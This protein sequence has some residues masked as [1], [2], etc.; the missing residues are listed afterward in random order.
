MKKDLSKVKIEEE[1]LKRLS[2]IEN[3][4]DSLIKAAPVV[5]ENGFYTSNQVKELLQIGEDVL[6]D[7]RKKQKI[8]FIKLSNFTFR[9]KADQPLFKGELEDE[10]K[11]KT[12]VTTFKKSRLSKILN[13]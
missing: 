6:A 13:R 11:T 7:L 1:V 12:E 4:L 2:L 3:K 8:K 10:P 5:P 9:Y